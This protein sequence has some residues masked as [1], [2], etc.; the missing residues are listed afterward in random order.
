MRISKAEIERRAYE[1]YLARGGGEG[2]A[3]D[4]WLDAKLELILESLEARRISDGGCE[5][6]PD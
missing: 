1:L 4:D 6:K 3:L 2:K 5:K